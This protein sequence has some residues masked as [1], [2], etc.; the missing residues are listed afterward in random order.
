MKSILYSRVV[1]AIAIFVAMAVSA[2]A[3]FKW[4]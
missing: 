1:I 2:G 4:D 3:G